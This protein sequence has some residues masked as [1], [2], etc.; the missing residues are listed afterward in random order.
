MFQK[1]YTIRARVYQ[2]RGVR[3]LLCRVLT[4][5]QCQGR[6]FPLET[7]MASGKRKKEEEAPN[8]GERYKELAE[9]CGNKDKSGKKVEE[10]KIQRER[11]KIG[12]YSTGKGNNKM[13]NGEGN[14]R[15]ARTVNT[16]TQYELNINTVA[17]VEKTAPAD[18][19]RPRH[20]EYHPSKYLLYCIWVEVPVAASHVPIKRQPCPHN[21]LFSN[22]FLVK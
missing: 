17:V 3:G 12:I 5:N 14:A 6:K 9:K 20:T 22:S 15:T 21:I 13:M 10:G 1:H 8:V 19:S 11:K 7:R 18:H 2:H 16:H 4:G